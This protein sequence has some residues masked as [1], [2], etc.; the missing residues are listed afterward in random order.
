MQTNITEA[1]SDPEGTRRRGRELATDILAASGTAAEAPRPVPTEE[2]SKNVLR[3]STFDEIVGQDEAVKMMR[4]VVAAAKRRSEPLDHVLLV[5]AAGT[6]KTTFATVIAH[7]L[8]VACYALQAPVSHDTLMSL[9]EVMAD[10]DVLLVDEIHMQAVQER[11]GM[12]AST[13]P[14]VFLNVLEDRTIATSSG[15]LPYPAITV[16]G[17][18][19]DEGMLPDPFLARFPLRPKLKPYSPEDMGL[20]AVWNAERL[21]LRITPEAAE[22]FALAS[23]GVPRQVNNYVRNAASLIEGP[24]DVIDSDLAFEVLH[25]LNG[26]TAD[27]LTPDMQA[28]LIFLV[29]RARHENADGE[30]KY[31]ASVNTIATAIGKSRDSKAIALRVEPYLIEQGYVQVGHGG[32]KLTD[33]GVLRARQLIGDA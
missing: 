13:K 1:Y 18:T 29:T 30:V 27:G 4:R 3:P 20:M 8:G 15:M 25:D 32:R 10:G 22:T 16:I 21:N 17:A 11:R 9:R 7:E 19:T 24:T 33:E 26:V 28:M 5:G 23:R 6:G 2:R 31:Q 12:E 14:E